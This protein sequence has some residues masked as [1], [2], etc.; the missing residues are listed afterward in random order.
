MKVF[1]NR[2][3]L[4]ELIKVNLGNSFNPVKIVSKLLNVTNLSLIIN[5][6][7]TEFSEQS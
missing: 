2:I 4:E 1:F 3:F 7:K 5:N 6:F